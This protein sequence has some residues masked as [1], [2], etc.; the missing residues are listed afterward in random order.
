[1]IGA[2]AFKGFILSKISHP[3]NL[4]VIFHLAAAVYLIAYTHI[5][6]HWFIS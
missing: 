3:K 4:K 6:Q 1:M 5:T 2:F